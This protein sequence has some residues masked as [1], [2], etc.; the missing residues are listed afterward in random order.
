MT[1]RPGM[2][3]GMGRFR[4]VVAALLALALLVLPGAPMRHASATP[5]HHH[6]AAPVTTHDC[7]GQEEGVAQD[8]VL[9]SH[10]AQHGQPDRH[11]GD[12]QG[13]ACC[14][15]AQCPAMVGAPPPATADPR[16]PHGLTVRV[17]V[18][19]SGAH[20]IDIAPTTPPPRGA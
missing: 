13:L 6:A 16:P 10:E 3:R 17:A 12:Q 7:F 9:A 19:G 18:P 2:P 5:A 14:A 4:R 1:A 20:G 8:H 11:P 15:A